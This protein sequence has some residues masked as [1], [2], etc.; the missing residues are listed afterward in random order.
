MISSLR[1]PTLVVAL[2]LAMAPTAAAAPDGTPSAVWEAIDRDRDATRTNLTALIRPGGPTARYARLFLA[3]QQRLSGSLSA[4]SL[5][6][7]ALMTGADDEVSASARLGDALVRAATHA[8][9]AWVWTLLGTREDVALDTQNADRF[10][11]LYLRGQSGQGTAPPGARDKA[12]AYASSDAALSARL[13]AQLGV[14]EPAGMVA[15]TP[16]PAGPPARRLELPPTVTVVTRH[17]TPVPPMQ[18]PAPAE[19]VAVLSPPAPPAAPRIATE[20]PTVPAPRTGDPAHE[21]FCSG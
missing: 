8:D 6:F 16:A 3:E 19:A 10:A 7:K 4:A 12:L 13:H 15:T 17:I 21:I 9:D 2:T 11:L 1:W 20:T 14:P 5:E 18:T